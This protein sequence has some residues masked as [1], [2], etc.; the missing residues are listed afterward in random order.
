MP[1][2]LSDLSSVTVVG[3]DLAKHLFQVHTIDSAGH[4]IVDRALRRKD[5]PAFFAALP[6]A[7]AKP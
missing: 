4:I 1:K 7:Y 5:E 2:L 3:L 6:Q